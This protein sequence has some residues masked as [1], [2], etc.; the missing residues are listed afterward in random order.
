MTFYVGDPRINR[1]GKP[2]G[3]K[4]K[5]DRFTMDERQRLAKECGTT[6]LEFMLSLMVDPRE[7]KSVRLDAAKY[8]APYMHK[9]M[10]VGLEIMK[11]VSFL[12]PIMLAGM[13][14]NKL[15]KLVS[16]LATLGIL[17]PEL[18]DLGSA[19]HSTLSS[20]GT[21]GD[22]PSPRSGAAEPQR[23]RRRVE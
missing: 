11:P 18:A 17:P 21:K 13:D 8:A 4:A 7:S 14:S 3:A 22:A 10:P 1:K 16:T 2:K 19:P 15:D 5:I 20:P 12:D 9:K 23:V 6:P